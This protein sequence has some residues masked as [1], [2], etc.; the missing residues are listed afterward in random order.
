MQINKELLKGSTV[1]LI[2][3]M[4]DKK[5]MY[6]YEMIKAIEEKSNGIF[7][8]KEGTLYPIL[9]TLEGKGLV[10]AYWDE[11]TGKRKRKYYRITDKGKMSLK[12]KKEEWTTFRST[13]DKILWEGIAWG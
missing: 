10:E 12:E 2:L 1:I 5:A 6:G 11:G 3:K 4:L 13:V 9:H 8:F 7:T